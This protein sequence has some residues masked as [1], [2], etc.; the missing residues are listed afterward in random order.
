MAGSEQKRT[1]AQVIDTALR[2][3]EAEQ[4]FAVDGRGNRFMAGLSTV[5]PAQFTARLMERM[6]RP[7]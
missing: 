2:A 7:D 4:S 5:L 1:P 3:L 6:V